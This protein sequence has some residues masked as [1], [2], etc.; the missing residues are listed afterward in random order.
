MTSAVFTH[1]WKDEG[2]VWSPL[3]D[4]LDNAVDATVWDLPYHGAAGPLERPDRDSRDEVLELLDAQIAAA[5]VTESGPV[6]VGH[7]LGGF[8][9]L[10]HAVTRPGVAAGLALIATGP[11][12]KRDEPRQKWND[13]ARRHADPDRPGEELVVLQH[14]ALVIERMHEIDVPVLVITGER[15]TQYDAARA[16]FEKKLKSVSSVVIDGA[17]HNVHKTHAPDVAGHIRQWM[18]TLGRR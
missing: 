4:A 9:S 11:G 14:D 2:A 6:L 18:E 8:V 16:V 13:W 15:D 10:A 17:G 5:G 3:I 1:G 12:F 7:S